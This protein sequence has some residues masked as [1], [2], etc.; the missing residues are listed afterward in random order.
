MDEGKSRDDDA[1]DGL[2]C[3]NCGSINL[4]QDV[5]RGEIVCDD[6][7]VVDHLDNLDIA[8][9]V[10][11]GE[12]SQNSIA[13]GLGSTFNGRKAPREVSRA[14]KRSQ[15]GTSYLDDLNSIIDDVVPEGRMRVEVKDLLRKYDENDS[16]LWR[17]RKKLHGGSDT[18]YRMRVLVAGAL[19]ALRR[20]LQHNQANV[21]AQRWEVDRKDLN[22]STTMFRRFML[23]GCTTPNKEE[24]LRER[25][26]QLYFHLERFREIL[27]ERVGWEI[28]TQVLED[29]LD[30]LAENFEPVHDEGDVEEPIQ[31]TKYGTKSSES[32][33]WESFLVAMVGFGMGPEAITW[34]HGRAAP[35]SAGNITRA[36]SRE[37]RYAALSGG[38]EEE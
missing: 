34:L 27:A 14:N 7:G 8:G 18:I 2:R 13:R 5:V 4:V 24:V 15:K 22:Y 38:S 35:S 6:C 37:S 23:K 16:V 1:N 36:Y 19:A 31:S 26:G 32:A 33:A 9:H 29:A 25:R 10:R 12:G 20:N 21:I 28:A 30:E 3:E 17:K 11:F